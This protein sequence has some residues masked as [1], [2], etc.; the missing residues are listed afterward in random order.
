MYTNLRMV[1]IEIHSYCNR[2]C[3]WCPNKYINR[4]IKKILPKTNYTNILNEL[5]SIDYKGTISYS[6][7]NE[8]FALKEIFTQYT[9]IARLLLPEARLVTNTNGD[10][11]TNSILDRVEIDELSIMDY[12][13]KGLGY[14]IQRME[15]LNFEITEI[16]DNKIYGFGH[17]MEVVYVSDWARLE[18]FGDRAGSLEKADKKI[19]KKKC[20]EPF[21]FLGI[22]YNGNVMPCCNFRSDNNI[23]QEFVL[24]NIKNESIRSIL[25]SKKLK[26]LQ[27]RLQNLDFP[28]QC[29]YC[30]KEEGRYT[31]ENPG[32]KY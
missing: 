30:I 16:I 10:Y 26:D 32:I 15:D 21:H 25:D 9:K 5:K 12:D 18:S 6:R 2:T 22:D 17:D 1:E 8:P 31:R 4:K 28:E 23:H 14:C 13:N 20:Y 24:G 27:L 11:L 7:Y 19:R 29:K 3:S